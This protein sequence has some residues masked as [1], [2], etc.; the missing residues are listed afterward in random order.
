MVSGTSFEG[1]ELV[2]EH[3]PL[4]IRCRLCGVESVIEPIAF[5]CPGCGSMAVEIVTGRELQVR[6]IELDEIGEQP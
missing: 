3:V 1:T 6:E 5:G 2:F 4:R